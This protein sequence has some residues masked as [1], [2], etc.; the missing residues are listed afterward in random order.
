VREKYSRNIGIWTGEAP[1]PN[2]VWHMWNYQD[3]NERTKARAEL[4]KD[5]EWQTFVGK[6]AGTI[7]EM[8]NTMLIPTDF[9]GLK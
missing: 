4:F 7:V 2:E 6:G 1:Q 9:S 5:P 8:Q 3:T